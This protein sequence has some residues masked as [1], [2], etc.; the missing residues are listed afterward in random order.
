MSSQAGMASSLDRCCVR[1]LS[2]IGS[3]GMAEATVAVPKS[4]YKRLLSL[5][6]SIEGAR[7][8]SKKTSMSRR[9]AVLRET[10]GALRGKLPKDLVAWQRRI[11]ASWDR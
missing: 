11:R 2:L 1:G 6:R 3:F 10:A 7:V 9:Q 4:E 8:S 5:Q